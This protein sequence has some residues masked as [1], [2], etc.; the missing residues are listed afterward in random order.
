[1]REPS[2][3]R[4]FSTENGKATQKKREP[5]RRATT[6]NGMGEERKREKSGGEKQAKT[7]RF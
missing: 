6:E 5:S 7:K 2:P 1:L 3:R 4:P